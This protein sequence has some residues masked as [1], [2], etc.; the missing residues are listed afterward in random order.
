MQ[1]KSSDSPP[2][3]LNPPPFLN[4]PTCIADQIQEIE[5]GIYS[6]P[7]VLIHPELSHLSLN[8]YPIP[9]SESSVRFSSVGPRDVYRTHL[10]MVDGFSYLKPD[11]LTGME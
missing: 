8:P 10:P 9:V 3:I 11:S 1:N 2:E 7:I 5:S 4:S 6:L